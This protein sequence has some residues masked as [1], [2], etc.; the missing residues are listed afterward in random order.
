MAEWL[1]AK[2][3]ENK[4]WNDR[5][6]SIRVETDFPEFKAGQFTRLALEI[7][8]EKVSRPFSLVNSP[9][10][11]PLDFYFIEVPDG[12]LSSQLVKL[13]AGDDIL[14]AP[15]AAGLLTLEQL[16]EAKH[17]YLLATGTGVGPFLSIAKTSQVWDLFEKVIL[18]HAVRHKDEL[19]YPETIAE[20]Q[21]NHPDDFIY[22]PIVSR[23]E[24]DFA[25]SGRIPEAVDD[26]R[27]EHRTGL[28][29]SP[30]DSQFMLCG[31]PAMV[32]DTM[33][34]LIDKRGLKKHSRRE[35][36]HISIEKY[37]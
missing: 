35:P 16:P 4:Q 13:Q 7:D 20:V 5:L 11:R 24:C 9:D 27:L 26:G 22:V 25:L 6:H 33:D 30:E 15:K 32:Q 36:G 10:E 34:L 19:T 2:V 12:V 31:N 8:G 37:W 18:V 17:L 23:E 1:T 28:K 3:V 14:V 29:I 21:G